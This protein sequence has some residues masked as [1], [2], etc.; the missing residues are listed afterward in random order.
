MIK[1][2][3]NKNVIRLDSNDIENYDKY[4]EGLRIKSYFDHFVIE[5]IIVID[6][7]FL[8][9]IIK[10]YKGGVDVI[11]EFRNK[12]ESKDTIVL[13]EN[14]FKRFKNLYNNMQNK[15]DYRKDA[16]VTAYAELLSY[17]YF[18]GT[19]LEDCASVSLDELFDDLNETYNYKDYKTEIKNKCQEILKNKYKIS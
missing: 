1:I 14:D 8:N 9:K 13:S 3:D 17:E 15:M 2:T 5:L 18:Q 6:E 11:D 16:I 10:I 12:I 19:V 7:G 4:Y